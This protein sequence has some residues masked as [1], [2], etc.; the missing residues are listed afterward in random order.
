MLSPGSR[1]A[2]QTAETALG[3]N[4]KRVLLLHLR[5]MN[6]EGIVFKRADAPYGDDFRL[7]PD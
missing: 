1:G 5:K 2:I 6:R 4:Q 7:D 3:S